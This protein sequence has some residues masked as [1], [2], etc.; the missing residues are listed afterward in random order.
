MNIA[1]NTLSL[2]NTKVGMGNYIVHLINEISY[3]NHHHFFVIIFKKTKHFFPNKK[4]ITYIVL[5]NIFSMYIFRV[6]FEQFILPFLLIIY[7]IKVYHNPGFSL[8]FFCPCKSVVTIADMT[9]FSHPQHHLSKKNFYFK[10]MIPFAIKKADAV[11]AISQSTKNDIL[12][13]VFINPS[14]IHTIPLAADSLFKQKDKKEAKEFVKNKYKIQTQF[15]LFVG[16]LEPR[17]NIK[18]LIESFSLLNTNHL[19][20]IVGKKGWLYDEIFTFV[21]EKRLENKVIF[22]GYIP[23]QDLCFFYSA[24]TLFVYPSFYEGFG[25]PIIEA[26]ACGCPVITSNNSSMKEIAKDAAILISPS[27]TQELFYAINNLLNSKKKQAE[28]KKKGFQR[29]KKYFWSNTGKKTV[30]LYNNFK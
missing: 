18:G 23:D 4:N 26:M 1:I 14:K 2:N 10:F 6:L 19:L 27:N 29:V 21:K 30:E 15:I 12:K 3:D 20:V 28:L 16:M 22:T 8:P 25:I 7:N 5:P 9:F 13:N 24:A 11:I 17:K